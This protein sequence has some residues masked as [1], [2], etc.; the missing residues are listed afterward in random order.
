M[1]ILKVD[2]R[3]RFVKILPESTLDLL[4]IYR[5]LSEGDV[6]YSRTSR[7]IKKERPDGSIDSKRV[8]VT[9]GVT[10][11]KKYLDSLTRR[12]KLLGKISYVSMDLDLL[13]KHHSLNIGVG[14]E[15]MVESK[16]SFDRILSFAKHF[17][18]KHQDKILCILLDDERFTI[19]TVSDSGV[20]IVDE[21]RFS[22]PN[23]DAPD[24]HIVDLEATY[25]RILQ[26]VERYLEA[27]KAIPILLGTQMAIERFMRYLRK[28]GEPLLRSIKKFANVSEGS[29]AG[30]QEALRNKILSKLGIV[31]KPV[32]DAEIVESFI[33]QMALDPRMVALGIDEVYRAIELGALSDLIVNEDFLWSN[34]DDWRLLKIMELVDSR[35][36]NMYVILSNTESGDKILRLGGIVGILKYPIDLAQH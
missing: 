24:E 10:L 3:K 6:I 19:A 11:E 13:G 4:N 12:L 25:L 17:T 20:A 35:R 36:L 29:I 30:L 21:G 8:K 22:Y 14:M 33:E 32:K 16:K 31:V 34:I 15:L 28:K 18:S 27:E 2:T 7:E 1:Q 9:I 26:T 5:M 23:K